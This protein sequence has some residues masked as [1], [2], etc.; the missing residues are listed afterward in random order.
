MKTALAVRK[1]PLKY[2]SSLQALINADMLFKA[3]QRFAD[4]LEREL[5]T[6]LKQNLSYP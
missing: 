4:I 3:V 6:N 1:N 5:K 2:K